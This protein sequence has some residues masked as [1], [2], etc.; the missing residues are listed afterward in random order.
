[1]RFLVV[2]HAWFQMG[3][4]LRISIWIS[5]GGDLSVICMIGN[6]SMRGTLDAW[7]TIGHNIICLLVGLTIHITLLDLGYLQIGCDTRVFDCWILWL[8]VSR[9]QGGM[10]FNLAS[11]S[12]SKSLNVKHCIHLCRIL[13]KEESCCI[14]SRWH[15]LSKLRK[16]VLILSIWLD[17]AFHFDPFNDCRSLTCQY[18]L[19]LF[20]C[21]HWSRQVILVWSHGIDAVI[22]IID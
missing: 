5:P 19:S 10:A 6:I 20:L 16:V 15:V 7:L 4:P 22:L 3:S 18:G 8:D 13:C 12:V 21:V 2:V 9:I 17:V 14:T 1:M 11:G